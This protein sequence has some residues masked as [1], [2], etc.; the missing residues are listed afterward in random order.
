MKNILPYASEHFHGHLVCSH[1]IE[2]KNERD[3]VEKK[4]DIKYKNESEVCEKKIGPP[5]A[6]N[7]L[8]IEHRFAMDL[9]F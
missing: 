7:F 3:K 5:Q 9:L 4:I 6:G 8:T 2:Y 1:D